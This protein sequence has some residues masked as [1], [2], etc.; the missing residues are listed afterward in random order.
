MRTH[1]L[2]V[3][4]QGEKHEK[5][6][7]AKLC[8]VL[9]ALRQRLVVTAVASAACAEGKLSHNKSVL[10]G[11]QA[12]GDVRLL[13]PDCGAPIVD[14]EIATANSNSLNSRVGNNGIHD[15][16]YQEME[17]NLQGFHVSNSFDGGSRFYIKDS[18]VDL[19]ERSN[20]LTCRH[21]RG[22]QAKL[23]YRDLLPLSCLAPIVD[24]EPATLRPGM[25]ATQ[26]LTNHRRDV[27]LQRLAGISPLH[28][29]RQWSRHR[30]C[31]WKIRSRDHQRS[32]I[33]PPL[34]WTSFQVRN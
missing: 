12:E 3:R 22:T 9:V 8:K 28:A 32:S 30:A 16:Q 1:H 19:F 13:P 33:S 15:F 24:G 20:L 26:A 11:T 25:T 7:A 6:A 14:G 2:W 10:R 4:D 23:G 29:E 17:D 18:F 34:H 5:V 31:V 27:Q 21:R